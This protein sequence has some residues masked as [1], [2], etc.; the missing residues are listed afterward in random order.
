M[1]G[2]AGDTGVGP[3]EGEDGLGVVDDYGAC[4]GSRGVAR[5]AVRAECA[6][7]DI[8]FLMACVTT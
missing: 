4:P 6:F 5:V 1:T 3:G 2:G 7:M 8:I